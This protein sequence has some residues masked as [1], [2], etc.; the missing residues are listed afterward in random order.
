MIDGK[1]KLLDLGLQAVTSHKFLIG[2]H[3]ERDEYVMSKASRW[4]GYFDV[5]SEA[6]LTQP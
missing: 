1:V 3:D 2:S 5:L 6:T 4:V